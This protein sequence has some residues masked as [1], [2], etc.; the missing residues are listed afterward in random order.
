MR[1][2]QSALPLS[3]QSRGE[4]RVADGSTE[5]PEGPEAEG[6]EARGPP[7]GTQRTPT[8]YT[9]AQHHHWHYLTGGC[10]A[11]ELNCCRC[12]R[13]SPGRRAG[14]AGESPGRPV[15]RRP[16]ALRGERP[17]RRGQD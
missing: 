6:A 13:F 16:A 5:T 7:A 10:V 1:P 14:G 17:S 2:H 9:P 15:P 11:S 12:C 8:R 4:V 3:A